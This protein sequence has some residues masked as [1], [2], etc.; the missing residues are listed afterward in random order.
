MRTLLNKQQ[1]QEFLDN[2][3]KIQT[4]SLNWTTSK[5]KDTYGY[6]RLALKDSRENTLSVTCGGGYDMQGTLLGN[7]INDNF[8]ELLKR[9]NSGD[10]YGLT[11]YNSKRHK[12]QKKSSKNTRTYVDGGC[13]IESMRKILAKIGFE[14]KFISETTNN[15][16]F[17]FQA[18]PKGHYYRRK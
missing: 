10:F 7:F 15:K 17:T 6:N 5:A 1:Q 8:S 9:I 4:L 3:W 11:H 13:G 12:H 14:F 18:L 2:N 16:I